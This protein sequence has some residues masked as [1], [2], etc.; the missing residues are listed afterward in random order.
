MIE[1]NTVCEL[2]VV[3]RHD[4]KQKY[5]F[6]IDTQSRYIFPTF[7]EAEAAI[8]RL[9]QEN[10]TKEWIRVY[11]YEIYT[12]EFGTEIQN[13]YDA[14][15]AL[16]VTIYLP[17][18]T[19]WISKGERGVIEVAKIYE[20]LTRNVDGG[21]F[22]DI[23]IVENDSKGDNTC[24]HLILRSEYNH[25][26]N[27]L[28]DMMPCSLPV[29]DAYAEALLSKGERYYALDRDELCPVLGVPYPVVTKFDEDMNDYLFIPASFSGFKYDMF[30]DCKAAYRKNMHPMWFYVAIPIEDK[31]VLLPIT[32][33]SDI[34]LMWEEYE[35]LM[36][37]LLV[38]ERLIDFVAFNLHEIMALADNPSHPD[39]FLW[40]M[41]KMDTVF[42]ISSI[43]NEEKKTTEYVDYE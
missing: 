3:C 13:D 22:V 16:D 24:E 23:C 32:V 42:K 10:A 7:A 31:T 8:P 9:I 28:T 1:R 41:A 40:N 6:T 35:H 30:F 17:D 34:T 19:R 27:Y 11:R 15:D 26:W 33:S 25:G 39:Y 5:P 12:F 38:T 36:F 18:G 37:D 4:D 43:E 20:H 29:A 21:Y 14:R 2:H